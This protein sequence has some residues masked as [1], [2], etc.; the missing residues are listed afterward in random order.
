MGHHATKATMHRVIDMSI[1]DIK[2]TSVQDALT[3]TA[4]IGVLTIAGSVAA[5]IIGVSIDK[6]WLV[7]GL[8]LLFPLFI[9]GVVTLGLSVKVLEWMK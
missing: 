3:L 1:L 9:V 4:I 8:T 7:P 6:T 5:L 2:K